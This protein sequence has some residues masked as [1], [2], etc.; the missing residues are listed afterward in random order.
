[1]SREI[2]VGG[3]RLGGDCPVRVQTMCNTHTN[4]VEASLAQCRRLAAAGAELI[5]LTVPS[6]ADVECLREIHS[7]LRAEG[8]TAPLVADVHFSSEIAIACAS[9]VEK[10]RINPGT[11]NP[12]F[13]VACQK[14]SELIKV[15]KEHGT[16]LRIGMN[17]GSL[18]SRIT[19]LYG[20]TPEAMKEA[21]MEW[22]RLC[23]DNDFDNIVVS[24]KASNTVVM[25]EPY[26]LLA[27]AMAAEGMEYPLHLGVTEAGNGDSA[28]IKSAVA[29]ATLLKAG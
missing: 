12:D 10:V 24:L 23:R 4:D 2:K 6:M 26:R 11:F 19:N 28:R 8:I 9:F 1:M 14:L 17:H 5:R 7:R 15:C 3:L 21:A 27:G 20:N 25:L 29:I 13:S 22:L 18:G 16:V